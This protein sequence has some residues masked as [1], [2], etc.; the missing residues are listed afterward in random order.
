MATSPITKNGNKLNMKTKALIA[1]AVASIVISACSGS[2]SSSAP[3]I[4]PGR[5]S[6]LLNTDVIMSTEYYSQPGTLYVTE[7]LYTSSDVVVVDGITQVQDDNATSYRTGRNVT[8]SMTTSCA[9]L[10]NGFM[11]YQENNA[12]GAKAL[13]MFG[14]LTETF[15]DDYGNQQPG[16]G[17]NGVSAIC[18]SSATQCVEDLV[19]NSGGYNSGGYAVLFV[20]TGLLSVESPS[21]TTRSIQ[22]NTITDEMVEI[23]NAL[24]GS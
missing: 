16:I 2:S 1:T 4:D 6:A 22:H 3:T 9:E 23:A 10:E 17:A 5:L 11:C 18:W 14:P 20:G 24:L 8:H 7:S 19:Y 12:D 13:F 21:V 15:Y